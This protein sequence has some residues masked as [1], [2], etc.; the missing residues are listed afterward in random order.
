MKAIFIDNGKVVKYFDDKYKVSKRIKRADYLNGKCPKIE[1][2]NENMYCY[3][4]IDGEML[5]NIADESL[6]RKFLDD[7]QSKLWEETYTNDNFLEDCRE[8]YE[9]KTKERV[10]KLYGSEIDN[11]SIINGLKVQPIEYM[12]KEINWNDF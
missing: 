4:Y 8:M 10:K 9:T 1:Y 2:V 3:D 7:C 12:L 6:M 5:S 11:I